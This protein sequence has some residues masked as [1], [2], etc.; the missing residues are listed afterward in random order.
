MHGGWL[1]AMAVVALG[2]ALPAGGAAA[3]DTVRVCVRNE[4]AFVAIASF[5]EVVRSTGLIPRSQHSFP[6][7][8][9]ACETYPRTAEVHVRVAANRLIDHHQLC[10]F[11]R[12]AALGDLTITVHGSLF[13]AWCTER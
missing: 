5:S 4:A 2:T 3:Q 12:I 13:N 6:V 11:S 8:Q 10:A 7:L 1:A 9:Q